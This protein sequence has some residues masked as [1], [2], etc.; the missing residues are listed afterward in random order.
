MA[1]PLITFSCG[2]NEKA[3]NRHAIRFIASV[4]EAAGASDIWACPR[5]AHTIGTWRM[6]VDADTNVV[7]P[8]GRSPRGA[9]PLGL[10]QL[11]VPERN[12]CQPGAHHHGAQPASGGSVLLLPQAPRC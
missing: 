4:W 5:V 10:R 11:G 7:D 3:M 12:A 1:K 9:E 6:G 2:D 8:V